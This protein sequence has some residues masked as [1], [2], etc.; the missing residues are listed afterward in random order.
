MTISFGAG[1]AASMFPGELVFLAVVSVVV[2]A[3][4]VVGEAYCRL[5]PEEMI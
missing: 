3:V 1:I 4:V 2:V 5:V